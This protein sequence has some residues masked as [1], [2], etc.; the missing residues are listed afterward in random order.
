M[1]KG[2]QEANSEDTE[3]TG[4]TQVSCRPKAK[5][6]NIIITQDQFERI[7]RKHGKPIMGLTR[8][9][10]EEGYPRPQTQ[11]QVGQNRRKS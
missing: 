4:V 2:E 1:K 5:A 10:K 7:M 6:A 8:E 9:D 3:K 11:F